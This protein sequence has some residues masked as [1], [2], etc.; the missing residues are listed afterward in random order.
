MVS[1]LLIP[2]LV[3]EN[4]N[5]NFVTLRDSVIEGAVRMRPTLLPG[6]L[7]SVR[8]NLNHQRRDL[9]LFEIGKAF[10]A[11]Q[12]ESGLPVEREL[13]SIVLTGGDALK[14]RMVPARTLDFYD[15]KGAL[16]AALEAIGF[17]SVEFRSAEAKHLRAGQTAAVYIDGAASVRSVG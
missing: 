1:T 3:D 15:A 16:E 17:E 5:D 8:L 11:A 6:L 4:I 12:G 14:K 7:D 9:R 2:G 10:G 13:F